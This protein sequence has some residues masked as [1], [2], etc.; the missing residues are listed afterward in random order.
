FSAT[1]G[2]RLFISIRSG[3]SVSQLRAESCWPRGA[4]IIR[5]LSRRVAIG[6][7]SGASKREAGFEHV[8]QSLLDG[9]GKIEIP[10]RRMALLAKI[11]TDR[12]S[13]LP[14]VDSFGGT[15]VGAG[16]RAAGEPAIDYM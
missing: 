2:S 8:A 14:R 5:T 16:N 3:A 12:N 4:R 11:T 15:P 9:R 10:R 7:S 1:S 13:H 6:S